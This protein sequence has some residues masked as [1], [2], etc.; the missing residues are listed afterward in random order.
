MKQIEIQYKRFTI[1]GR[2]EY[3]CVGTK[4]D[5]NLNVDA[6]GYVRLTNGKADADWKDKST[7]RVL[8]EGDFHRI[9][10]NGG[11]KGLSGPYVTVTESTADFSPLP[12]STVVSD[13]LDEPTSF[14]LNKLK[15]AVGNVAE[16]VAERLQFPMA[17][18]AEVLAVEQIDAVALAIYNIEARNQGCIIGDMTGVGKGR[19]AACMIR[20]GVKQG[21]KPIFFTNKS[22]LF[23]RIYADLKDVHS[24]LLVPLI[25]N[26]DNESAIKVG[27]DV[28]F[29]HNRKLLNEGIEIGRVPDGVDFICCTYSQFQTSSPA[30]REKQEFIY[31][32]ANGNILIMDESH[33]ASGTVEM[34]DSGDT[35]MEI[36]G[37]TGYAF[38]TKILPFV[39]GCV[40]LSATYAK[41][42]SNL[43]LYSLNTCFSELTNISKDEARNLYSMCIND[44]QK[45]D[46]DSAIISGSSMLSDAISTVPEQ[47]VATSFLTRYG[48]FIR[49]EVLQEG[50][51][52]DYIT[53]DEK[54]A[55]NFKGIIDKSGFFYSNYKEI[56]KVYRTIM[57]NDTWLKKNKTTLLSC[58]GCI[59]KMPSGILSRLFSFSNGL[60]NC[61]KAEEVVGRAIFHLENG[62][63]PVVSIGTTNEAWY[64]NGSIGGM[65]DGSLIGMF[66]KLYKDSTSFKVSTNYVNTYPDVFTD[67]Q[68]NACLYDICARYNTGKLNSREIEAYGLDTDNPYLD[69]ICRTVTSCMQ[70][71]LNIL[72]QTDVFKSFCI[73]PIDFIK[74]SIESKVNP[75]TG[76]NYVVRECTGRTSGLCVI[77]DAKN[78]KESFDKCKLVR[79]KNNIRESYLEFNNNIADV[80]I[81]NKAA[82]TGENAHATNVGYNITPEEVKQRVMIIPQCELDVNDEIQKRGRI[83]RRGQF[84]HIPPM[85]EYIISPIPAEMKFFQMLKSKLKSLDANTTSNQRSSD[86]VLNSVDYANDYGDEVAL[87]FLSDNPKLNE[88]LGDVTTFTRRKKK[89]DPGAGGE[90][91]NKLQGRLFLLEAKRQEE[92]LKIIDNAYNAKCEQE[93]RIGRYKLE[94]QTKDYRAIVKGTLPFSPIFDQAISY[95]EAVYTNLFSSKSEFSNSLVLIKADCKERAQ[96]RLR[97]DEVQER[98]KIERETI[99]PSF[100]YDDGLENILKIGSLEYRESGEVKDTE[101]ILIL[102]DA[103]NSVFESKVDKLKS[104][105]LKENESIIKLK[106]EIEKCDKKISVFDDDSVDDDDKTILMKLK[107][108]REKLESQLNEEYGKVEFSNE[109]KHKIDVLNTRYETLKMMFSIY[110]DSAKRVEKYCDDVINATTDSDD[111]ANGDFYVVFGLLD[112]KTDGVFPRFCNTTKEQT[113]DGLKRLIE[114]R[115]SENGSNSLSSCISSWFKENNRK[116]GI[117]FYSVKD[118]EKFTISSILNDSDSDEMDKGYLRICDIYNWFIKNYSQND[119]GKRLDDFSQGIEDYEE[120][121]GKRGMRYIITGNILRFQEYFGESMS[122]PRPIRFTNN[123]GKILYGIN[124]VKVNEKGTLKYP[125]WALMQKIRIGSSLWDAEN[126]IKSCISNEYK[127]GISISSLFFQFGETESTKVYYRINNEN[128]FSVSFLCQDGQKEFI[129]SKVNSLTVDNDVNIFKNV[130]T[131]PEDIG[132]DESRLNV[133][134]GGVNYRTM[135]FLMSEDYK[136]AQEGKSME[137]MI[138]DLISDIGGHYSYLCVPS[139]I[140][141]YEG[142]ES[143]GGYYKKNGNSGT[144]RIAIW[145]K[146]YYDKAKIPTGYTPKTT[147]ANRPKQ[148]TQTIE[149]QPKKVLKSNNKSLLLEEL[150]LFVKDDE[151]SKGNNSENEDSFILVD[152]SEKAYAAFFDKYVPYSAVDYYK[153]Q[154]IGK[155]FYPNKDNR[156]YGKYNEKGGIIFKKSAIDAEFGGIEGLKRDLMKRI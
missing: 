54:G 149:N 67:P 56:A 13:S 118:N 58:I 131:S 122:I 32:I 18:L 103:L 127:T 77:D 123:D 48:Q 144:S 129:L 23:S 49:R 98:K 90:I 145:K 124:I 39:K 15:E 42:T 78:V 126:F 3:W 109:T 12:A 107:K 151:I 4:V 152:Y 11:E 63:K 31:K 119:K 76:K 29:A 108:N 1:D 35:F 38:Q 2:G 99:T 86:N 147:R 57:S 87:K 115:D 136:E 16:F 84:K 19:V 34:V 17:E 141:Y 134:C 113:R 89:G 7:W 22:N 8:Y 140:S 75:E 51:S 96:S 79:V 105:E 150:K 153:K 37:N 94:M 154:S 6:I 59:G 110:F 125:D 69:F 88:E 121:N 117:C 71:V 53:I 148:E 25:I 50:V 93:K 40:F 27:D 95:Q 30:G 26:N 106:A 142:D 102:N 112:N 72:N 143:L 64:G 10:V 80:L 68:G 100:N 21:L 61:L 36:K 81:I 52:V 14:A 5:Y 24:G 133:V 9:R 44:R 130:P 139:A 132:L 41:F 33:A 60:F 104:N 62:R 74:Q 66:V 55:K 92:V 83:N 101:M 65:V 43:P 82:A 155:W 91:I 114:Y 156:Q 85:Y 46:A 111:Y 128:G 70:S 137:E 47:E 73:S 97:Y 28:L 20:Y 45:L 135:T 120:K 116:F 146:L 138:I